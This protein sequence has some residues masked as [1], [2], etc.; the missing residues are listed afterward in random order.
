MANL[1]EKDLKKR[2]EQLD[3]YMKDLII[4]IKQCGMEIKSIIKPAK[5]DKDNIMITAPEFEIILSNKKQNE[6]HD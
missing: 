2:K 5:F 3:I 6:S 4:I 1:K